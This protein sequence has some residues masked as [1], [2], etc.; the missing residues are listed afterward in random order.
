MLTDIVQEAH[1]KAKVNPM[2][3]ASMKGRLTSPLPLV[4]FPLVHS[5]HPKPLVEHLNPC[6]MKGFTS[7]IFKQED[8]KMATNGPFI[9]TPIGRKKKENRPEV[10]WVEEEPG[11]IAVEILNPLP[12]DLKVEKMVCHTHEVDPSNLVKGPLLPIHMC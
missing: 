12:F 10:M 1:D 5:F 7:P 3:A 11:E 4:S 2:F 6:K 8:N 9:Y